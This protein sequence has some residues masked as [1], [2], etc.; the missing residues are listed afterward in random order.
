MKLQSLWNVPAVLFGLALRS[1]IAFSQSNIPPQMRTPAALE[2]RA[3]T[4]AEGPFFTTPAVPDL[5]PGWNDSERYAGRQPGTIS[6]SQ[7]ASPLKGKAQDLI[8]KAQEQLRKNK[9]ADA[10]KTLALSLENAAARPYALCLLGAEH[11]KLVWQDPSQLDIALQELEEGA[12]LL[13]GDAATQ[14]NL[15]LALLVKGSF[16]R[17]LK[18]ALKAVQLNP[19]EPKSRFVT[20]RILTE[21]G[22]YDEA[23]HHLKLAANDIQGAEEY[24]AFVKQRLSSDQAQ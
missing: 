21:L 13:P 22:Q 23:I 15:A 14:S 7:L 2:S 4:H 10:L 6:V 18:H 3:W 9:T 17:G 11:L 19:S 5:N 24:I 12:A 16:E 20:G 8:D 1:S